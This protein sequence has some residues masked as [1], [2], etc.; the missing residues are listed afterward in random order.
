M[1]KTPVGRVKELRQAPL[2]YRQIWDDLN[3]VKRGGNRFRWLNL[4]LMGGGEHRELVDL[5]RSQH[6]SGRQLLL[7]TVKK[8]PDGSC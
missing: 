8:L 3:C 5:K 2:A 6:G 1:L 7:Q 4:K